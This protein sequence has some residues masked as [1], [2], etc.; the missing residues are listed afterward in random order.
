[1]EDKWLKMLACAVRGEM[2]SISQKLTKRVAELSDR[3]ST[4]LP[5]TVE[6]AAKLGKKVNQHLETMGFSW[7]YGSLVN[8]ARFRRFRTIG[9]Y[10]RR[11]N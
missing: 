8:A 9:L 4:P 5:S 11:A 7:S 10:A 6:E 2:D 1:M 3:Y